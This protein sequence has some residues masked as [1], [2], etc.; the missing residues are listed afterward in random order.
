MNHGLWSLDCGSRQ[1]PFWSLITWK[2]L[3]YVITH[4][5][6]NIM[7]RF[8]DFE[9]ASTSNSRHNVT[10]SH[11]KWRLHLITATCTTYRCT[12]MYMYI[13]LSMFQKCKVT[14]AEHRREPA[15]ITNI[16]K[17]KANIW[18]KPQRVWHVLHGDY[19][20]N[21]HAQ[22]ASRGPLHQPAQSRGQALIHCNQTRH[23]SSY[24]AFDSRAKTQSLPGRAQSDTLISR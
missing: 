2:L 1:L 13:W 6:S 22:L 8:V 11:R 12:Y 20:V 21:F 10:Q 7:H 4:R 24:I 23:Y 18:F 16:S 19:Q 17:R 14:N 9:C 5:R 15:N 3:R